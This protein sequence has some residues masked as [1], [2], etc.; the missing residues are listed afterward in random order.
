MSEPPIGT[1]KI[2]YS[3][4]PLIQCPSPSIVMSV[5]MFGSAAD[6]VIFFVSVQVLGSGWALAC[7]IHPARSS[8]QLIGVGVM[9]GVGVSVGAGVRVGVQRRCQCGRGSRRHCPCRPG[10]TVSI[11]RMCGGCILA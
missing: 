9:V 8:V 3:L 2:R 11:G 1:L 7:V 4:L 10:S 5:A 6:R